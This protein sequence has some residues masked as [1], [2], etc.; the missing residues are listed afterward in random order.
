MAGW[1]VL[2][3]LLLT[4][5]LVPFF[6]WEDR[7]QAATT[8]FLQMPHSRWLI[9]LALAGL[10]AADIVLP[11]PSSL[12]NLAAGSL[13]G[14]WS[15][16]AVAWTGLMVSS[17]AGYLIGQGASAT[18]LARLVGNGEGRAVQASATFGHWGLV[19]CRGVPVLAEASVVLAGFNRMPFQRFL[20]VCAL[21]NLGIAAAYSAIGAYAVDTGSFLVAFA[22]AICVPALGLFLTRKLRA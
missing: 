18:A 5:I 6:L 4:A 9:A 8:A 12:V 22:G 13:L 21:S 2:G 20:A 16:T 7:I 3:A 19:V 17:V 14:L 10:L 15:G 1:T 11:V